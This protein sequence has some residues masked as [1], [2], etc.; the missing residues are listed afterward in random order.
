MACIFQKKTKSRIKQ[1]FSATSEGPTGHD[2]PTSSQKP[3]TSGPL[4]LLLFLFW[5][6]KHASPVC[7]LRMLSKHFLSLL[8]A[9]F[10]PLVLRVCTTKVV[11]KLNMKWA[12][13]LWWASS[14]G[15]GFTMGQQQDFNWLI[16]RGC[17]LQPAV[18]SSYQVSVPPS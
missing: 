4:L 14:T 10:H 17:I 18:Q 16:N 11:L 9:E 6:D 15:G 2:I 7:S 1:I 12:T 3:F 13:G 5:E 8:T